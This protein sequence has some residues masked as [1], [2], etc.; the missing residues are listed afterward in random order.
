MTGIK[1]DRQGG[2][3]ALKDM[4]KQVKYYLGKGHNIIIFPQGTRVPAAANVEQ[5]PYQ[6]GI[7]ALYLAANVPVVPAALNSGKLWSKGLLIKKSGRITIE[8]LEPIQTGLSRAEF[9]DVL[10]NRIEDASKRL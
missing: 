8:F 10:E 3:S 1:V 5:Y 2:A 4:I 9:M 6:V 7:A